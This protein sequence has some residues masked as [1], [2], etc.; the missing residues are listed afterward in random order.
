ME[1]SL[2][3][4]EPLGDAAAEEIDTP[5]DSRTSTR[6]RFLLSVYISY[7]IEDSDVNLTAEHLPDVGNDFLKLRM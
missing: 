1:D 5:L 3:S 7:I 4:F 6:P 2:L